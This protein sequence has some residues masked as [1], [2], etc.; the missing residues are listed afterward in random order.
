MVNST[1]TVYG[2]GV[3]FCQSMV[4]VLGLHE[5]LHAVHRSSNGFGNNAGNA[6]SKQ[7]LEEEGRGAF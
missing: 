3:W 7:V 6:T 2:I 4:D 1:D 5:E